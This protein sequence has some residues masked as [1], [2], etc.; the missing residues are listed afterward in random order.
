M[1]STDAPSTSAENAEASTRQRADDARRL[2]RRFGVALV[3]CVVGAIFALSLPWY[4]ATLPDREVLLPSGA[5]V[6]ANGYDVTASGY[7]LYAPAEETLPLPGSAQLPPKPPG[8]M[9]GIP[10]IAVLLGLAG[11]FAVA[12]VVLT[13]PVLA[14]G[15]LITWFLAG[16]QAAQLRAMQGQSP[17]LQMPSLHQVQYGQHVYDVMYYAIVVLC[18]LLA[19]Q[20]AILR[21]RQKAAAAA[22]ALARG[23]APAPGLSQRL[24]VGLLMGL[25]RLTEQTA[26]A[27]AQRGLDQEKAKVARAEKAKE[28]SST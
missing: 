27:Q 9:L 13:S 21:Q 12:S 7:E 20:A 2:L 26:Q 8:Q 10:T 6:V 28:R 18:V 17:G 1:F 24:G 3:V 19:V 25:N 5:S 22:E 4:R 11:A 14:C 16:R 23:E 15:V